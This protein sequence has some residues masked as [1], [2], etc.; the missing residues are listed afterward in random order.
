MAKFYNTCLDCGA[1]LD[2]GEH[3]DCREAKEPIKQPVSDLLTIAFDNAQNEYCPVL[4]IGRR[5]GNQIQIIKSYYNSEAME[6]YSKLVTQA[7]EGKVKTI[8]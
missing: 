7:P 3:C 5:I 4:T 8:L 1:N 6:M 2:P